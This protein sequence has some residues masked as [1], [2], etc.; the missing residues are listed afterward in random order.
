VTLAES[1]FDAGGRGVE[2]DLET[3]NTDHGL[4]AEA[5]LF[6]ES[7]SRVIVSVDPAHLDRLLSRAQSCGVAATLIGRTGSSRIR[8]AV[9]GDTLIDVAVAEAEQIWKTAIERYFVKQV[10]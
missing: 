1:C 8:I 9:G 10:A 5:T 3:V 4:A 7:A 6:G 2:V